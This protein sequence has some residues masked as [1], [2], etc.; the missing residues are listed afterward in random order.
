[1]S[2]HQRFV[3]CSGDF[4]WQWTGNEENRLELSKFDDEL[5]ER[6]NAAVVAGCFAYKLDNTEGRIVPG[7]YKVFVQLNEMRFSKRRQPQRMSSVCQPFD[8][9]KFN[10]NKVQTKEVLTEE[11]ILL[12]LEISLLSNHRGFHVGFNSL[13]AQASVNHLHFHTW[14][15]EYSSYLE[16]AEVIP[17][18]EDLF[19]VIDYPTTA[20]VFELAPESNLF[21]LTKKI[22]LASS[23]LIKNEVAHNLH[24]MRGARCQPIR[25]MNGYANHDDEYSVLRVF[26][27]PRNSVPGTKDLNSYESEKRPIALYEFAG[28]LAIGTRPTYETFTEEHFCMYLK[29]ATL[30]QEEFTQHKNA[31]RELLNKSKG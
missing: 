25:P 31:I 7:K 29:R 2:H 21:S 17:I 28:S 3:Y 5:Q 20:F 23:Y 12:A 22:H 15:S 27:W 10:F 24:I 13:C 8:P 16:T 6:W 30:P 14:Y 4:H 19:E 9:E 18:C 1:M 11:S 26:L